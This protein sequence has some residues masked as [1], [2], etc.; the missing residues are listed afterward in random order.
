MIP[1]WEKKI[2]SAKLFSDKSAIKFLENDFGITLK[3]PKEKL[4]EVDT[5]VELELRL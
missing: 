5:I 1:S 3:I 2:K 4:D